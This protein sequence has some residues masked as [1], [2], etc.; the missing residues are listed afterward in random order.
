MCIRIDRT[1][2]HV[3]NNVTSL[4]TLDITWGKAFGEA[5][6]RHIILTLPYES[7]SLFNPEI[8]KVTIHVR[9]N[10]IEKGRI[11]SFSDSMVSRY[12]PVK[13]ENSNMVIPLNS[14]EIISA[15]CE[16]SWT[17]LK[18]GERN[19]L[20]SFP[21]SFSVDLE[22]KNIAEFKFSYENGLYPVTLSEPYTNKLNDN[23]KI[24]VI[25]TL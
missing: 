21:L 11:E 5:F 8:A 6:C 24:K 3:N 16:S 14:T 15:L 4:S 18:T 7:T 22:G 17:K 23:E 19:V 1:G 2:K 12:L 20:K 25:I 10:N 9:S 13:F